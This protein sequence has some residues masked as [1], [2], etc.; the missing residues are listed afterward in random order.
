[1]L[2]IDEPT[3]FDWDE[4]IAEDFYTWGHN[5]RYCNVFEPMLEDNFNEYLTIIMDIV[6]DL[7]G[8]KE[9]FIDDKELFRK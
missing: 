6:E 5:S 7:Y 2:N 9:D 8:S 4:E 1:M 3:T